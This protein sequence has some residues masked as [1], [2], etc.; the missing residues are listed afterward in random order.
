MWEG[1]LLSISFREGKGWPNSHGNRVCS[2]KP[3]VISHP[4]LGCKSTCAF[5][6]H[7]F[8]TCIIKKIIQHLMYMITLKYLSKGFL[9]LCL[10][11]PLV[12]LSTNDSLLLFKNAMS[13]VYIC[14]WKGTQLLRWSVK[15]IRNYGYIWSA[16]CS[17]GLPIT[18]KNWSKCSDR[19]QR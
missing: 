4:G 10:A 15:I 2:F 11:H 13:C 1:T 6:N 9:V 16:G 12:T 8:Y 5:C 7:G 14:L 17:P 3:S 19:P 18:R